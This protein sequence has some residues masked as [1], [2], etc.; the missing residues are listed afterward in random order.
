MVI[1]WYI[2]YPLSYRHVE[3]LG[4]ERGIELD[5]S[6]VQRWVAEYGDSLL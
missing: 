4:K 2:A 6:T 1:R 3:E 5:H